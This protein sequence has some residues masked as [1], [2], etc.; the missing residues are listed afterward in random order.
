MWH[1]FKYQTLGFFYIQISEGAISTV[2]FKWRIISW[3]AYYDMMHP[4][5]LHTLGVTVKPFFI[6]RDRIIPRCIT[7]ADPRINILAAIPQASGLLRP[8]CHTTHLGGLS[9]SP[10]FLQPATKTDTRSEALSNFCW[11]LRK[12]SFNLGTLVVATS[13]FHHQHSWPGILLRHPERSGW[14]VLSAGESHNNN[15]FDILY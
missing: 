3:L 6:N 14:S 13:P 7:E 10:G 1:A 11:W 8:T 4:S 2:D 5:T 9:L 15:H 12:L